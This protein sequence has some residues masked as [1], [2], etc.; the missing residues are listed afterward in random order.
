M[1]APVN[2]NLSQ[3]SSS[4]PK[5]YEEED[6]EEFVDEEEAVTIAFLFEGSL[7]VKENWFCCKI[8]LLVR[9]SVRY[10]QARGAKEA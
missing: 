7:D 10:L 6:G 4:S 5:K 2:F 1:P 8:E 9:I 3:D